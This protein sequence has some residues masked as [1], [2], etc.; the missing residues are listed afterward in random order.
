MVGTMNYFEKLDCTFDD[1]GLK[2]HV[3]DDR[4]SGG[5]S[6]GDVLLLANNSD[7]F[8]VEVEI[9]NGLRATLPGVMVGSS[10]IVLICEP[11]YTEQKIQW[12]NDFQFILIG[13]CSHASDGFYLPWLARLEF[14]HQITEC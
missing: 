4:L 1:E 14:W 5:N 8:V 11:C 6:V 9:D 7:S 12:C 3:E 13:K 10:S 2:L